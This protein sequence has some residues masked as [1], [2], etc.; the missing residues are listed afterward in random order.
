MICH[1]L[2]DIPVHNDDAHRHFF[3]LTDYRFMSPL[4]YW[5]PNHYGRFVALFELLL[6]LGVTPLVLNILNSVYTKGIVIF[7][8]V[9]YIVGYLTFYVFSRISQ[10]S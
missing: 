1:S 7:I 9:V 5:D 4:S 6:V 2:L 8:D 3:P 10:S